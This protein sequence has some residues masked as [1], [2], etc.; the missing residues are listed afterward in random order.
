[1]KKLIFIILIAFSANSYAATAFFTGRQEMIQT[2]SYQTAW[3]C[4]YQ[5]YGQYFWAVF[6]NSCPS[7]I[8][9]Y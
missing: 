1:M 5:V 9:V 8:E 6:K 2:V 7:S 4:Q 3:N